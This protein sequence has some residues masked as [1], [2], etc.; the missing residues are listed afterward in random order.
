MPGLWTLGRGPIACARPASFRFL[1]AILM[2]VGGHKGARVGHTAG[3]L[4]GRAL[5]HGTTFAALG[6][7]VHRLIV[8]ADETRITAV[9]LALILVEPTITFIA[10]L[11]T[12]VATEGT[13]RGLEAISF[14][15]PHKHV[16]NIGYVA[17][18]TG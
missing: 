1:L 18:G 11:H 5:R 7:G 2:L 9:V 17:Y 16:Q 12:L 15:I 10:R 4:R 6:T 14:R 13:L 3:S 8:F